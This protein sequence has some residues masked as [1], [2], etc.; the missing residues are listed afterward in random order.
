M[1]D[2]MAQVAS[3]RKVCDLCIYYSDGSDE[4]VCPPSLLSYY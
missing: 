3:E 1:R 4:L 2:R